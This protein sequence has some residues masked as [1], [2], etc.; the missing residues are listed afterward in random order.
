MP[1]EFSFNGEIR[2]FILHKTTSLFM[3]THP[4]RQ[5][6]IVLCTFH[7]YLFSLSFRKII[8]L[9]VFSLLPTNLFSKRLSS[10]A[11]YLYNVCI[12]T[13]VKFSVYTYTHE[14]IYMYECIFVC[15]FTRKCFFLLPPPL[16]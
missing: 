15:F 2:S 6:Y 5:S 7:Y 14:N 16:Q 10:S 3:H 1:S 8:L 9:F 12:S 4:L 11:K 13:F